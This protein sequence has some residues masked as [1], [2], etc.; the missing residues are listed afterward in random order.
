MVNGLAMGEGPAQLSLYQNGSLIHLTAEVLQTRNL[1]RPRTANQFFFRGIHGR[2]I[3]V[4]I[5][6]PL[7]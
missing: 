2:K 7:R 1:L 4:M 3:P 5:V 6:T